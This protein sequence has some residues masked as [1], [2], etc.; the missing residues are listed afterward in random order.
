MIIKGWA[1]V[2]GEIDIESEVI[3]KGCFKK[4]LK[5]L[6]F[7]RPMLLEH[8]TDKVIGRWDLI[9]EKEYG[10]WCEGTVFDETTQF[11]ID[12]CGI[13]GLSVLLNEVKKK[14][15]NGLWYHVKG[16]IEEISVCCTPMNRTARIVEVINGKAD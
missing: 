10:L 7:A 8:N 14:R 12:K 6:T 15:I 16:E 11:W 4:D 13:S 3:V 1:S 5:K 9:K 2:F